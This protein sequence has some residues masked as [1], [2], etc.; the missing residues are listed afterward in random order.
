[1]TVSVGDAHGTSGRTQLGTNDAKLAR[2]AVSFI[3]RVFRVFEKHAA[4]AFELCADDKIKIEV[5]HRSPLP[6]SNHTESNLSLV[7]SFATT[8]MLK[9]DCGR[10]LRFGTVIAP[11]RAQDPAG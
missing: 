7:A 2:E 11:S 8:L 10:L 1:M 3:D 4:L 5:W 9:S 6:S